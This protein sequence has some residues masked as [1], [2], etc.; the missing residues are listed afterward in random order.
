MGSLVVRVVLILV[1][2]GGLVGPPRPWSTSVSTTSPSSCCAQTIAV[3][4]WLSNTFWTKKKISYG[5]G[6]HLPST[7]TTASV[8]ANQLCVK[9]RYNTDTWRG[10]K[11]HKPRTHEHDAKTSNC[12][13]KIRYRSEHS[14]ARCANLIGNDGVLGDDTHAGVKRLG[15]L[16]PDFVQRWHCHSPYV[17]RKQAQT[18]EKNT[19]TMRETWQISLVVLS[20][21]RHMKTEC[22][23]QH[24]CPLCCQK[25]FIAAWVSM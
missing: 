2:C 1:D 3:A 24:V 14:T 5:R 18:H 4:M 12:W 9:L 25:M 23:S 20:K 8:E 22:T 15:G 16:R 19:N 11:V 10:T 6:T 21:Q 13:I 17:P 7:D